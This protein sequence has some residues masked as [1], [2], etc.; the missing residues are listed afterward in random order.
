LQ[1]IAQNN[2]IKLA[3]Q[4]NKA[5]AT[6]QLNITNDFLVAYLYNTKQLTQLAPTLQ[7][8]Q[9]SCTK[10]RRRTAAPQQPIHRSTAAAWAEVSRSSS[11]SCSRLRC[12]D[13]MPRFSASTTF[14]R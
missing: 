3:Q 11:L 13:T 12:R 1:R 2:A 6:G 9:H 14:S 5:P 8:A 10:N 7:I 4:Q